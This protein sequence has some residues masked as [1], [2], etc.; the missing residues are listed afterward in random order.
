[1][2]QFPVVMHWLQSRARLGVVGCTSLVQLS[3]APE[4]RRRR[5]AEEERKSYQSY[6]P[7]I[8]FFGGFS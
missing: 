3:S 8:R 4:T 6:D 2:P 1:M 7:S 5:K